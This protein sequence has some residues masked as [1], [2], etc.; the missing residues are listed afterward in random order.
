MAGL[1]HR[2]LHIVVLV[3]CLSLQPSMASFELIPLSS[4]Q[5]AMGGTS[6][7]RGA[8]GALWLNPASAAILPG[9]WL[10]STHCQ[11]WGLPELAQSSL[12]YTQPL[13]VGNLSVGL[14]TFGCAS[15][16]ENMACF[17]FATEV[18]SDLDIGM[19]LKYMHR[20]IGDELVDNVISIDAGLIASPIDELMVEVSSHNIGSPTIGIELLHQDLT[21]GFSYEPAEEISIGL[22]L[23]KQPPHPIRLCIGEEFGLT[24]WLI[25]RAGMKQSPTTMTIGFG[26][27]LS[28]MV[29]D[30][31]ALLHPLLG[32]THSFSLSVKKFWG[33]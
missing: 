14:S 24:E 3:A 33:D 17:S 9:H 13:L 19:N 5:T 1:P 29:L 11:L 21:A 28:P 20:S 16:R 31:A 32:T 8:P 27:D 18:K 2:L 10:S 25:Q 23:F 30:Y 4:R 12:S 26:I 22:C 15:Y 6:G 7:R